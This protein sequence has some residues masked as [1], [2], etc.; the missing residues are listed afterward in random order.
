MN[1]NRKIKE[2]RKLKGFTLEQLANITGLT[3]GYLSR[4]ERSDKIPPFATVQLIADAL[5]INL[6][7][8]VQTESF[9]DY[10]RNIEFFKKESDH[11]KECV[12]DVTVYSFEPLLHEYKNRYMAPFLFKIKK[13]TTDAMK[14]DSEEFVYVIDGEIDLNYEEKTYNL[15]VG[16]CFYLDSRIKHFFKNHNEKTAK[17]IAVN[18][19]VFSL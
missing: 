8:L 16:D 3:K 13:G 9:Q 5:G 12:E 11:L 17:L 19:A 10:S 2:I 18:F 7:E 6:A 14:H 1:I 4:I 15:K